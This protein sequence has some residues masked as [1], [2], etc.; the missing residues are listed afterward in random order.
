MTKKGT[1]YE[2]KVK[3][4]ENVKQHKYEIITSFHFIF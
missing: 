2:L 1:K 3:K 4:R